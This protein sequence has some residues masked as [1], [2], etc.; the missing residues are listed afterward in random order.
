MDPWCPLCIY[1]A[2]LSM[3]AWYLWLVEHRHTYNRTGRQDCGTSEEQ[4]DTNPLAP[5]PSADGHKAASHAQYIEDANGNSIDYRRFEIERR[6]FYLAVFGAIMTVLGAAFLGKQMIANLRQARAAE[7]E[8]IV[9]NRARIGTYYGGCT[10]DVNH[11]VF[12]VTYKN[13][14]KTPAIN[15]RQNPKPECMDDDLTRVLND[16]NYTFGQLG[17]PG[18]TLLWPGQEAPL[19]WNDE[20]PPGSNRVFLYGEIFYDDVFGSN[21]WTK[22]CFQ[23]DRTNGNWRVDVLG[24]GRG[25]SCD[26]SKYEDPYKGR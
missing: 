20:I 5:A 12:I 18:G 8:L 22:F 4:S 2:Y 10:G 25:N 7:G 14:G 16:T 17:H 3:V 13:I 23:A 26:E 19:T 6:T 24:T 11:P 15:L 1:L 9:D 21:R